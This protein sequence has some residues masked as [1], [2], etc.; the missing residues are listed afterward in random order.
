MPF[1]GTSDQKYN[2][3]I[4]GHQR[5][6][7]NINRSSF[8]RYCYPISLIPTYRIPNGFTTFW[9]WIFNQHTARN[10]NSYTINAFI[11]LEESISRGESETCHNL[12]RSIKFGELMVPIKELSYYTISLF[13]RTNHFQ[14]LPVSSQLYEVRTTY[15]N[16]QSLLMSN[17]QQ[18]QQQQQQ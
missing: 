12:L 2:Q 11:N 6:D 7:T 16:Q 1:Y 9:I 15:H 4:Q 17:Q 10:Y 8:C 13:S 3:H 14:Q 5:G 18:Q